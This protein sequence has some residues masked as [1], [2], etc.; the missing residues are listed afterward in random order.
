MFGGKQAKMGSGVSTR[1][2]RFRDEKE[3]TYLFCHI[4]CQLDG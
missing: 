2:E 4:C 1:I 3:L